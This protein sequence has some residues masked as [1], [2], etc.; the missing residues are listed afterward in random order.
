M[1][2][3]RR[4]LD[5]WIIESNT[6]YR[7]VPFLVVTDWVQQGRLLGEDR[8]RPSGTAEW[9]PIGGLP[10]LAAYMPKI[11]EHRAEDQAEALEPVQLE[12]TWKRRPEDEE[13]EVDMIPLIDVSLV[14]LI[15]F[16]MTTVI[17]AKLINIDLPTARNRNERLTEDMKLWVGLEPP[18]EEGAGL[19]YSLGIRKEVL[20]ERK[21]RKEFMTRLKERLS[22][23]RDRVSI[24]IQ[25]NR[26]LPMRAI[27]NMTQLLRQAEREENERDPGLKLVIFGEVNEP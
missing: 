22:T 6:V 10:S 25:A 3:K 13:M 4:F 8:V 19:R 12:F 24:R 15:F 21:D 18:L 2:E 5:V 27:K 11:D 20:L 9:Y 1:A 14:L 16:L 26:F 7:E 23:A 17:G